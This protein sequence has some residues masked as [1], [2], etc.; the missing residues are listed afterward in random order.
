MAISISAFANGA[1]ITAASLKSVFDTVQAF[2]N[3]GIVA[4]D[5]STALKAGKYQLFSPEFFGSPDPRAVFIT[6]KTHYRLRTQ[7]AEKSA[8]IHY[9]AMH[10]NDGVFDAVEGLSATVKIR[11]KSHVVIMASFWA[12]ESGNTRYGLYSNNTD[13]NSA[14]DTWAVLSWALNRIPNGKSACEFKLFSQK[15]YPTA[16]ASATGV[17]STQRTIYPSHHHRGYGRWLSFSAQQISITKAYRNLEPG[18]YSFF[19]GAN[20]GVNEAYVNNIYVRNRSFIVDVY[21]SKHNEKA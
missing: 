19:I 5:L 7:D 10:N 20:V 2:T 15:M 17:G 16:D 1:T 14:A 13:S 21:S 9:E 18:I 11:R 8:V 3:G 4:G 12:H 6:G